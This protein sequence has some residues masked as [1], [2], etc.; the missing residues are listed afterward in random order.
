MLVTPGNFRI[1]GGFQEKKCKYYTAEYPDEYILHAGDLIVTMTDLSKA[2]DTLG[3]GAIVPKSTTVYLHNQRVGLFDYLDNRL[4][5]TFV[6]WFMQ[7]EEYR[8]H[9][10][11][12][13]AGTTVKHTS[14]DRI[15]DVDI[16]LPPIDLQKKFA[17]LA[18]QSEKSKF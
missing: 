18:E 17:S 5:K 12:T 3:F 16:F 13:C 10:L 2:S 8:D 6:M 15:L 7:T 4:D 11:S 9:I 14:P 1:G